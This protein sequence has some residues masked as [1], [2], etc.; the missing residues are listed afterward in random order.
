MEI[1]PIFSFLT[2]ILSVLSPCILPILPLFI[3]FC[4]NTKSK[5]ELISFICGFISIFITV[6]IFTAFFTSIVYAYIPYVRLISSIILLIMGLFILI[7]YWPRFSLKYVK[8]E[9]RILNAFLLG[10]LT[11]ISWTPCYG[12]YLV[13][14][15]SLLITSHNSIY[16]IFNMLLYCIGFMTTLVVSSIMISKINVEKFVSKAKITNYLFALI[17]IIT[18]A[19]LIMTSVNLLL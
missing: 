12:A 16:S 8:H 7:D 2:G 11:S 17:L 10:L 14:L 5:V 4:L 18:S 1:L 13:S 9:N 6:I 3:G 19:Y 15:I